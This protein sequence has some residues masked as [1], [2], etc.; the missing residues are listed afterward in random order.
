MVVSK[1]RVTWPRGLEGDEALSE[2][3]QAEEEGLMR[4]GRLEC[5]LKKALVVCK[6]H[7]FQTQIRWIKCLDQPRGILHRPWRVGP[8]V[9][10]AAG[11]SMCVDPWTGRGR[12]KLEEPKTPLSEC[13]V[14]RAKMRSRVEGKKPTQD[15]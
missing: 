3:L 2:E 1:R 12:H 9:R 11:A 15:R 7:Y 4:A 14:V 13:Q 5:V 8:E 10:K 6:C